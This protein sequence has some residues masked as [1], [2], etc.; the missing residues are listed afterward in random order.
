MLIDEG[1]RSGKEV[2]AYAFKKH[3]VGILVGHKTAGM[4]LAGMCRPLADGSVLY[5]AVQNVLV[6]GESLEGIGVEPDVTVER[7][8]PY[9]QGRD[10]QLEAA[11]QALLSAGR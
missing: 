11:V 7:N 9:S 1:S 6:D 2:L 10:E 5:L 8:L 4:V 3:H